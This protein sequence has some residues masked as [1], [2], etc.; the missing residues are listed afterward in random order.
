MKKEQESLK[1][2]KKIFSNPEAL[3][4]GKE[5]WSVYHK[6]CECET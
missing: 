2:I 4:K 5:G 1:K 3:S 6:R